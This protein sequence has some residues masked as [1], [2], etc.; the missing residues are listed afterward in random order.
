MNE[1]SEKLL[2][3]K[4]DVMVEVEEQM[5]EL[6]VEDTYA[7][8][9]IMEDVEISLLQEKIAQLKKEKAVIKEWGAKKSSILFALAFAWMMG[10]IVLS[11]F[12]GLFLANIHILL[13][14]AVT[15]S[16]IGVGGFGFCKVLDKMD[17]PGVKRQ[18]KDELINSKRT[19][20]FEKSLKV[21]LVHKEETK[22]D[23]K[24]REVMVFDENEDYV[25]FLTRIVENTENGYETIE[26]K[27]LKS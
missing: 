3:S 23:K 25:K 19:E 18:E 2:N 27:R 8:V 17:A 9:K 4:S 13:G 26:A 6:T 5:S 24:W 14:V 16:I 12:A 22:I 1:M 11:V 7:V 21:S 20:L 15:L 10:S